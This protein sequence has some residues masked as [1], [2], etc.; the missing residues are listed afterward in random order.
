MAGG[1]DT[2]IGLTKNVEIIDLE[3]T[4]SNCPNLPFLPKAGYGQMGHFVYKS[5]P[6]V[7]GGYYNS[8]YYK[9]ALYS[10]YHF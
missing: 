6:L 4:K 7:C 8:A 2:A 5:N 1:G 9:F 3:T 10:I